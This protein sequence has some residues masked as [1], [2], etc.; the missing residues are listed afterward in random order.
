MTATIAER[1]AKGVA[2]LDEFKPGWEDLIDASIL[3]MSQDCNCVCGQVFAED[4]QRFTQEHPGKAE[5]LDMISGFCYADMQHKDVKGAYWAEE[6]G[7]DHNTKAGWKE[8][9]QLATEWLRVVS[10]RKAQRDSLHAGLD[11]LLSDLV[12]TP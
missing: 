1:V 10:E 3:D 5:E 2:W 4:F 12:T 9:E 6:M 8:Y 11:R 7:F